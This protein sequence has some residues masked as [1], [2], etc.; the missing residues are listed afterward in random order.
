M[1]FKSVLI[2]MALAWVIAAPA[3]A[4]VVFATT[5]GNA[6]SGD[7]LA[8]SSIYDFGFNSTHTIWTFDAPSDQGFSNLWVR[9]NKGSPVD[10]TVTLA[11]GSTVNQIFNF[12]GTVNFTINNNDL[13]NLITSVSFAFQSSDVQI[14][15]DPYVSGLA[16]LPPPGEG[17]GGEGSN[18]PEPASV[19]LLGAAFGAMALL[20]RRRAA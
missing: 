8:D 14:K 5:N 7:V 4:E 1:K 6:A 19:A 18:V 17:G 13:D 11:D 12:N 15:K 3:S 20:R 10:I 2:V 9:F 16:G